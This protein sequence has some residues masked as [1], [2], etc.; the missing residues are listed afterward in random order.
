MTTR[1]VPLKERNDS[2]SFSSF[3]LD[4]RGGRLWR[5]GDALS[6]R[7]KTWAV[8]LY[9]ADR[10]GVLVSRDELLDAIWPDV[11]VTPDTLTKSI[12]ELREALGDSARAP[13]YIETVHRRGFRFIGVA[14]ETAPAEEPRF[15]PGRLVG[16]DAELARL[17]QIF[18]CA[19]A[20]QRNIAFIAG[21]AGIGKTALVECFLRSV[22]ASTPAFVGRGVCIEQ[23][24]V[25]EPYM[26]VLDSLEALARGPRGGTALEL[27]KR[28]APTWLALMPW[29]DGAQAEAL[30]QSTRGM[31]TERMMREF[32]AFT[33]ALAAQA[34]LLLLLEDL[35]WSD[36]STVDL[37][38]FL[39]GRSE[40]ARMLVISTYRPAEVAVRDH[41]LGHAV[42]A[43]SLRRQ[44]ELIPLHE[45]GAT[46]VRDYIELR[47][48]GAPF[49]AQLAPVIHDYTD[50]NALFV[51][52]V[53]EHMVSR[54]WILD[55]N[56]GWALTIVPQRAALQVPEEARQ[57]IELQLESLTPADRAVLEA[58]SVAGGEFAVPV[59]A[60]ALRAE[61]DEVEIRCEALARA[62]RF[63]RATG[64][65]PWPSGGVGR[66]YA[67]V[68]ELY[69]E[70][71]YALIAEGRR[72]RLHQ[73]IAEALEAAYG[74]RAGDVAAELATHFG[75]AGDQRRAVPHLIA[76]AARARQRFANR[77]AIHY[78]ETALVAAAAMPDDGPRRS[79]EL[80]LRIRLAAPLTDLN[81]FSSEELLRNGERAYALCREVGTDEQRFQV[82][83]GLAHL[84]AV[85]ARS[86]TLDEM[87]AELQALAQ[88][89]GTPEHRLLV[90]SALLRLAVNGGRCR[91]AVRLG[92]KITAENPQASAPAL[93]AFGVD[94]LLA[95]KTNYSVALLMVGEGERA[96]A[97]MRAT[98]AA[99]EQADSP[100]TLASVLCFA[101]L[102]AALSGDEVEA[103]RQAERCHAHSSEHGFGH[104]TAWSLALRGWARARRGEVCEGI[105]D[106]EE[107]RREMRS[108]GS[109]TLFGVVSAM[110]FEAYAL[111]GLGAPGLAVLD[112]GLAVAES[113]RDRLFWP[114]LWRLK[115]EFL[116]AETFEEKASAKARSRRGRVRVAPA[117]T[118]AEACLRRA[119]ELADEAGARTLALRAVNSLARARIAGSHRTEVRS[120][121]EGH[122]AGMPRDQGNP[123]LEE[124]R[125]LLARLAP[126]TRVRQSS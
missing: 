61:P 57:L 94:P 43:T 84:H 40:G 46:D 73:R 4:L 67:F 79:L 66:R 85:R 116:L 87:A 68:H 65:V 39:A 88:R 91:E 41:A 10:P 117:A 114:E 104:W 19:C 118:E 77:E 106:L 102:L 83:Y 74:P 12:G 9:L 78:L 63:L 13:R 37:L 5:G 115:G 52:A 96:R 33:E 14:G 124:A 50:G 51:V 60:A 42:R 81:G 76:A 119:V 47:F 21:G 1:G 92:E 125:R 2:L 111:G 24:G 71:S 8:L 31:R 6:L 120:L 28:I 11:A 45:L 108:T 98:L 53:I 69:R 30:R 58:A 113:T 56:P 86:E 23:H 107:G 18:T 123:D 109:I 49:G 105:A 17:R 38:S 121:L 25:H 82:V 75:R 36:P 103:L 70:T 16:R 90:D 89:L 22:E 122:C 15:T 3:R 126:G 99:A 55:T 93:A 34:P 54:G 35:H 64:A 97:T 44:A 110:L 62:Q 27:L 95:A 112:E 20:G 7:P 101:A 100:F 59:V 72:Q 48:P 80:D 29:L 26:P 32:A